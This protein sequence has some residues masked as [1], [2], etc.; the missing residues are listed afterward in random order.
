MRESTRELLRKQRYQLVGEHSAVKLCHWL[1]ESIMRDRACYKQKFYGISSHRCLQMTPAVN[2]CTQKCL[3]CWRP[4]RFT[5]EIPQ[6]VDDPKS[7]I[8]GSIEA[9]RTL[10][11][12]YQGVLDQVN[13]KKLEE[14]QNP[15]NVAISLSGEPTCYPRLP[16][17]LEEF[18]KR[19]FTTFL[20]T[21]GTNP[22]I[23]LDMDTLPWNLYVTVAAPNKEVY[24]RLCNPVV[25]DA[26]ERLNRTIDIFPSLD[27]KKVMRL[28]M[29]KGF[30]MC[31]PASYAKMIERAEPTYVEVKAYMYVGFSRDRLEMD[32]MPRHEEIREFAQMIAENCSYSIVDEAPESR[33]IL[34][35]RK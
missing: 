9:Q 7:I 4:I 19:H 14:A 29:T 17:L 32:N 33:V 12:G 2:W 8:E 28:T 1:K 26:W 18:K 3:F 25:P 30:N 11:S 6:D 16:E 35:G 23:L 5:E 31:D 27:T 22:E 13:K 34:L 15:N 20:V 21:N 10:L 24:G